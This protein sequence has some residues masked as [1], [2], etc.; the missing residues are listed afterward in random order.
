M[1]SSTTGALVA[2]GSLQPQKMSINR[3]ISSCAIHLCCYVFSR[4][5]GNI[6]F[7]PNKKEAKAIER[8]LLT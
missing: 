4:S 3:L 7:L 2:A 6:S 5:H 1:G 8:E